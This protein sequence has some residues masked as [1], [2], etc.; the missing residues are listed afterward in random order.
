MQNYNMGDL[1]MNSDSDS[2]FIE[3]ISDHCSEDESINN[4][5]DDQLLLT[6]NQLALEQWDT[7]VILLDNITLVSFEVFIR[8]AIMLQGETGQV[9]ITCFS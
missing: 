6:Q 3:E 9:L 8:G 1:S 2:Q 5:E 4:S 7:N